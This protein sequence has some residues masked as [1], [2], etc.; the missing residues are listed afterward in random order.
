M[1]PH[2]TF[3][4]INIY[5]LKSIISHSDENQTNLYCKD[6]NFTGSRWSLRRRVARSGSSPDCNIYLDEYI[7]GRKQSSTVIGLA[8]QWPVVC[9]YHLDYVEAFVPR[10]GF[11][12]EVLIKSSSWSFEV[13]QPVRSTRHFADLALHLL[14]E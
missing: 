1:I 3:E 2:V 11:R 13:L 7:T 5:A 8:H 14:N 9:G 4:S 6:C 12:K 10:L